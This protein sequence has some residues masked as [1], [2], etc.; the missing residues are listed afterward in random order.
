MSQVYY[1]FPNAPCPPQDTIIDG[2]VVSKEGAAFLV[3]NGDIIA[4]V[5]ATISN[6]VRCRLPICHSAAAALPVC[7]SVHPLPAHT[8]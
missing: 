4:F 2:N 3:E 6:N 7:R 5:N 1:P 8:L